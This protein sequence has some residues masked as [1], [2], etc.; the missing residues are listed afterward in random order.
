[1]KRI[2]LLVLAIMI[3][4]FC[5][6]AQTPDEQVDSLVSLLSAKRLKQMEI[7]G[8]PYR[9]V[10]GPARFLHNN[11][12]L[13]CDSALWNLNTDIID[14]MGNVKILQ[15]ETVLSGDS[16]KYLINLDLAQFRGHLVELQ[17]K[18]HNTLRTRVLDYNTKDSVATFTHGGAMRDKDG[19]IIESINGKYDSKLKFFTFTDNVNMFTDSIFVKTTRLEYLSETG[20]AIFGRSTNAWKDDNMLSSESGWYNRN[21]ERFLFY[22]DVHAMSPDKEAWADSLYYYRLTNDVQMLGNVQLSDSLR[23]THALAGNVEYVDSLMRLTMTRDAAVMGVTDTTGTSRDSVWVGA[24]K[25]VYTT[26]YLGDIPGMKASAEKRLEDISTDAIA[27]YRTQQAEEARKAAEEAAQKAAE[28]DP[29]LQAQMRRAQANKPPEEGK[30]GPPDAEQGNEPPPA[31]SDSLKAAPALAE[32]GMSPAI[33]DSLATPAPLPDSLATPAP[34]PD[35][36]ATPTPLPDSLV[37]TPAPLP[38]SVAAPAS[39]PDSLSAAA[40]ASAAVAVDSTKIGFLRAVRNVRLYRDDIQI[41]TDSLEYCDLDSLVRLFDRP[42]IWNEGNRQYAAD[43]IIALIH[44][45]TLEKAN[46][47]SEAFI[48]IQEDSIRYDQIRGAEMMAYFN[49]EGGL[50]RFDALGGSDAIFY[51]KEDSTLATVSKSTAKM[52]TANFV[53][54]QLDQ[55]YYYD[56][57]KIDAYPLA[58]MR[59]EDR[60]LKG[61]Q[62]E[63]EGRPEGPGDIT[64]Y[65]IRKGNRLEYERRPRASFE[66]TEVYF[67]GYIKGIYKEIS[68]RERLARERALMEETASADS[69]ASKDSLD[70]SRELILDNMSDS[71]LL[72]LP[73]SV[74]RTLP[75]SV[76]RSLPDS[77]LRNLPDSVSRALGDSLGNKT[78]IPA[79]SLSVLHDS[80]AVAGPPVDSKQAEREARK[81]EM[82]E[83]IAARTAAREEKWARLDS[84]DAEKARVKE[85]KKAAKLRKKKLA[86]LKRQKRQE[87]KDLQ[88]LERYIEKFARKKAAEEEKARSKAADALPPPKDEPVAEEPENEGLPTEVSSSDIQSYPES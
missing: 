37:R 73:D 39:L 4:P 30:N 75:D 28:N 12:Y 66:Q 70:I 41:A 56:K 21:E 58:Q 11:T 76:L 55:V 68:D 87:E 54:G 6:L 5:L 22:D 9:K 77:V 74:L 52:M 51:L 8:V 27:E 14:A 57:A 13:L 45:G 67:P 78:A 29:N 59:R 47:L 40:P 25:F 88:R 46:L 18:D 2:L 79:D 61:F 85:E 72:A 50:R 82:E 17:D 64:S 35:S 23:R 42:L 81:R 31:V 43:S 1:M 24:E 36:L 34:L 10:E 80:T 62:W 48:I 26:R 63:P 84:L 60:E 86:A 65:T 33:P 32:A 69:L 3:S 44:N 83:K 20:L 16:L 53:D 19:Q 49:E 71:L 38:D 15:N 7:N